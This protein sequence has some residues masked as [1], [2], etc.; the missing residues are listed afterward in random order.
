MTKKSRRAF[1]RE[2]KK[3]IV[4]EYLEGSLSAQQIADREGVERFQIYSWKSQLE[5]RDKKERFEEL[6]EAG[7]NPDDVRRMM[8]LEEELEAYKAKVAEQSVMIDLLKKLHP[9]FQSEKKSSGYV[10]L[11]RQVS[12]SKGRVK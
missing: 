6:T 11:K 3:R 1:D 12:R 4:S 10:E 7:H 9:S 5:A 8:E 2:Y